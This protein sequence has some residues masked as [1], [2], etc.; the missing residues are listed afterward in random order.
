MN[1]RFLLALLSLMLATFS[2]T[3][4]GQGAQGFADRVQQA[5]E[6]AKDMSLEFVQATYVASLEREVTKQGV[7][8]FKKPGKLH[9][10]YAGEGGRQY[11]SDGKT[12]WIFPR[13]DPQIQTIPLNDETVPAEALSFLGGLGNLKRDFAVEEVDEKKWAQLKTE[14]G[15]LRW[16]ELT[17]LQKRS[18][19]QCLIM[20]FDPES[21]LAK[22]IYLFTESGNLS[23]YRITAVKTNSGLA[24]S[25]FEL[26]KEFRSQ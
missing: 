24:D 8:Q 23:H 10:D 15:S 12:L 13:G 16:L 22:E 1:K 20:G 4:Y 14:K 25:L 5:Y 7:A 9:I 26:K 6:R 11:L 3:V 2:W 21:Y 19:I 17:P 18:T